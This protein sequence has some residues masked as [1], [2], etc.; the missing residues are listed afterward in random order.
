[1]LICCFGK[2]QVKEMFKLTNPLLHGREGFLEG[3]L[4]LEN[5]FVFYRNSFNW[6][7]KHANFDKSTS[8]EYSCH[9]SNYINSA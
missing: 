2:L 4:A 5:K 9:Q 6:N 3:G 8:W 7:S 1:M